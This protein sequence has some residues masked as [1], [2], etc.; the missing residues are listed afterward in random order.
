M[1]RARLKEIA[2]LGRRRERERL[3]AFLVEGLR[4]V[5]AAVAAGAPLV[6]VLVTE[7]AAAD[8]RTAALLART[9]APVYTVAARD[10]DRISDAQTAQGVVA[11]ARPVARDLAG[12][13]VGELAGMGAV[14]LLDGVQDPGN[15]GTVI[16]TA[17]WFGADAVVAGPG[18]ADVESP[19]VVRA[20]MGGLWDVRLARTPDLPATL[21][22]LRAAGFAVY[23]AD[24][25]GEDAAAWRPASPAALVLGSEAHGLSEETKARLDGAVRIGAPHVGDGARGVESLNVSVAAGI[26]LHGWLGGVG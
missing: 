7:A 10:L 13:D 23:G 14:V 21:D 20:A 5:E 15:V 16:R 12:G 6:E 22:S 25:E 26:L 1:T 8:P 24:L 9:A 18:T 4:S 11:V 2:A 17:A 19:K 3:G